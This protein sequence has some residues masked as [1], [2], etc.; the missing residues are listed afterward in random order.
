MNIVNPKVV[1]QG[2]FVFCLDSF[3]VK[4]KENDVIGRSLRS[5]GLWE[6]EVTRWMHQNIQKGWSC[7]DIGMNNGYFTE[8]LARLTGPT[9]KTTSFEPRRTAIEGYREA[10]KMNDYSNASNIEIHAVGLGKTETQTLIRTPKSNEGASTLLDDFHYQLPLREEINSEIV[11]VSRLD[12]LVT[13]SVDFAKI[14]IEGSEPD[15]F[16]GFGLVTD[17]CKAIITELHPSHPAEFIDFLA[18]KYQIETL[19]GQPLPRKR[20]P[21]GVVVNVLLRQ[22]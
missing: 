8:L 4:A 18:S 1:S 12:S 2:D 19:T 10:Q 21:Y 22:K 13:D 14:D 5:R 16:Q 11:K 20:I 17:T 15:A 6:P 3:W 9:G 7:L